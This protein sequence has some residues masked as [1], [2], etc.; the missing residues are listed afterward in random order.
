MRRH[1]AINANISTADAIAK[2]QDEIKKVTNAANLTVGSGEFGGDN[3]EF[4]VEIEK[5]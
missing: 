5:V 1:T 3:A 4:K 2:W